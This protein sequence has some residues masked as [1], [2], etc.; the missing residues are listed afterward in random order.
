MTQPSRA[1][2]ISPLAWMLIMALAFLWGVGALRGKLR[3]LPWAS[4]S[5][6]SHYTIRSIVVADGGLTL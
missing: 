6:E 1:Y 3:R 4:A 5:D 2:P